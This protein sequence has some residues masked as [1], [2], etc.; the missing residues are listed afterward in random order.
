[1]RALLPLLRRHPFALLTVILLG[2]LASLSEGI[3]ITLF[4]PFLQSL[5]SESVSLGNNRVLTLLSAVFSAFPRETRLWL[6]PLCIFECIV[7]RNALLYGNTFLFSSI[8]WRI[9]HQLRCGIFRN[10]LNVSYEFLEERKTGNLLNT[11]NGQT[12]QTSQA[13]SAVAG[14]IT[15]ACTIVVFSVL[16]LLISWQLTL[17]I[18]V[19][20]LLISGLVQ[21][22]TRRI[23]RAG[24]IAADANAEFVQQ[25]VEGLGGMKVIRAFSREDYEQQRFEEVSRKARFAFM[26]LDWASAVVGPI[27]EILS[28]GVLVG[29]V[30]MAVRD[31]AALPLLMTFIF[32]L[33]RLQP[34]I[35]QLDAIRAG[36]AAL[37]ADVEATMAMLTTADKPY[38][39]SGLLPFLALRQAIVFDNVTFHYHANEKPALTRVNLRIPRGKTTAIV[40]PSGAGKSTLVDLICRFHDPSDGSVRIDG[41]NLADLDLKAWRGNVALLSQEAHVF[42]TTI[43][44]NIAFGKLGSSEQEIIEAARKANAHDFIMQLPNGYETNVG[45]RGVRLSGGQRQRIAL[46]RAIIRNAEIVILDE[47]TNALDSI[48]ERLIQEALANFGRDRTMIVIAHRLSTIEAAD[49]IIVLDEGRI[50]EQGKLQDMVRGNGL[51]SKMYRLQHGAPAVARI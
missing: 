27:S 13:L 33:Y 39:H 2:T 1:M 5:D 46:A 21:L 51:F 41:I 42:N 20:M 15:T 16:M 10:L 17:V 11:L 38:I 45:D 31:R 4:V 18:A 25:A 8:N 12:W 28:T 48:S 43:R 49:Q 9:C 19:A 26:R 22:L 30:M 7:F 50:L 3:G 34:K 29:I 44:E 6:I 35:R 37:M 14:L 40:G 47:A 24:R 36:L 23:V 32:M